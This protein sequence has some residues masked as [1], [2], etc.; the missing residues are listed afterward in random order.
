MAELK[1][2]A[3]RGMPDILPGEA[4]LMRGIEDKARDVFRTFGF[5]EIRTPILEETE[6]FTR[7]IGE[8]TDIVEKEMYSFTDRGGKNI[9]MRPEGTAS[10]IRAYIEHKWHGDQTLVK[11]HYA[12]EMFRGERPQK[13][14]Q[15]Q[16]HQI[17]AEIIGVSNPYIDAELIYS[18]EMLLLS[19]GVKEHTILINSLGCAEDRKNYKKVLSDYLSEKESKLCD[20]CKRRFKTNVLRV[21]DCKNEG[22]KSV[23]KKAPGILDYLCKDCRDDYESLKKALGELNVSFKEKKDL[24]RGLDYYTGTIFEVVH[25]SLGAQ[26]AV[27]A[28]GRYDGLSKQ[29]GG[30]EAGAT[31]YA[32]GVERL[33]LIVDKKKF[34][35]EESSVLV[36]P[37]D[38]AQ[39]DEAFRTVN[40]LREKGI[41]SEMDLTDRS[42]KG[43]MRKAGKEKRS[44]IIL[45]GED[46]MKSGKLLLKDMETGDQEA[47]SFD[48]VLERLKGKK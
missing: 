36:I 43:Q 16:F 48:E 21:L 23:V 14:R 41:S 29:M 47:L 24:V 4:E 39:R 46:E 19:F 30:P 11:L 33:M 31:G 42:F 32:I 6:V 3:L 8:D 22:C 2:R 40:A 45:I 25:P 20:N 27:A 35:H 37:V 9:S 13:G 34:S 44:H 12:G 17:G 15:R 18:L 28:G 10:I 38:E 7:S 26:D 5:K 1:Y